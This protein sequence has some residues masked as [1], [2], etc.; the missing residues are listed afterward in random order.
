[1]IGGCDESAMTNI[2][3]PTLWF[4]EWQ[5]RKLDSYLKLDVEPT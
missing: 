5:F 4:V 3:L 1:M 2:E